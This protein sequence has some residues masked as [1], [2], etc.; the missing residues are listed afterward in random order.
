MYE[1]NRINNSNHEK[2]YISSR[3]LNEGDVTRLTTLVVWGW[4]S[5]VGLTT[6]VVWGWW[7][8]VGLATRV[9]VR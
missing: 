6:M 9:G 1:Y 3:D 4:W 2:R 7:R 8:E 5:E